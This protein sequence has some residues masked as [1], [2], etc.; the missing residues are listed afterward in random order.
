MS[1][2]CD[3]NE[4]RAPLWRRFTRLLRVPALAHDRGLAIKVRVFAMLYGEVLDQG[5]DQSDMVPK[6]RRPVL[7][8]ATSVAPLPAEVS[9][10]MSRRFEQSRMT[11]A[12]SAT[13]FTIGWLASF[14]SRP[15]ANEFM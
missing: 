5:P 10:T 7:W 4:P 9:S 15:L 8:A 13:G 3:G 12:T 11:S 6:P 2:R 14:S 1:Q